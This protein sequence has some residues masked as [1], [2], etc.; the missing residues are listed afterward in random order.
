MTATQQKRFSV[1]FSVSKCEEIDWNL[2][3]GLHVLKK[4]LME[5]FI[6]HAKQY[7]QSNKHLCADFFENLYF[8]SRVNCNRVLL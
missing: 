6:L 1:K 8:F 3:F 2:Q 7:V 4:I 5:N